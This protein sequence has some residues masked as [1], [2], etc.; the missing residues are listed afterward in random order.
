MGWKLSESLTRK[1]LLKKRPSGKFI[2]QPTQVEDISRLI[3]QDS[4]GNFSEMGCMK[5]STAEWLWQGKTKHIPNPRVLVITTKSG[6]GTYFESLSEVLPDWDVYTTSTTRTSMVLGS[7]VV[8]VD[9]ALP[10]PLFMRPVVV[11]AHYH[12]F[13]NNACV[14]KQKLGE[15]GLPIV[16]EGGLFVMTE[17]R[18]NKLLRMHWDMVIVDEAHRLKNPDAQWT[19][20]IK[21]IKA[22]YKHVMTGTGFINNPA[23]IWSLLNFLFPN[24]YTSYWKFREKFC[25]ESNEAGYRKIV[26]I[27]PETERE[28][29]ELVRTVGVRRTM[30]EMFPDI[31]EPIETVVSVELNATQRKMYNEIKEE[32]HT[33]DMAGVPL[34]TPNVLSALNRLRQIAVATPE[35]LEDYFD[36]V[37]ERRIIKVKLRE[38]SS[39]LDAAMEVIDGLEWDSERR[40]QVVVFSNFRDPLELLEKRLTKSDI[41][42]LRLNTEMNE[43]TRYELWHDI[44][45]QKNHQ[46]F[47]T[48]LS[49]GSESINLS[50]ANRAIFLDQSWSMKDNIQAKGRIYRPGQTAVAQFIYIRAEDTVDQRVLESNIEKAGWFAQIFGTEDEDYSDT[51]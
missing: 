25:E 34:H 42:Y 5:T 40:D 29:K 41:P 33:Y 24:T 21:R 45:P 6:K 22:Q 14:P 1:P 7:K 31:S 51:E 18:C 11:V 47:L 3:E 23:E 8:P 36:P 30:I 4:S 46:V 28:F 49:L 44:F 9:V 32:L 35:V 19:R 13:T 17:P 15:N 10:D 37:G 20:N 50:C 27:K 2:M 43:K 26:G 48:T 16:E 12:C 39:K 38:P